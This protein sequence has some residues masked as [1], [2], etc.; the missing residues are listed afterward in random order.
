MDGSVY[1]SGSGGG[2]MDL[3]PEDSDPTTGPDVEKAVVG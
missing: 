3:K 2:G 1:R